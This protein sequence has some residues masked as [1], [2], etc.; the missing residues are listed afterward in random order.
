[1]RKAACGGRGFENL[2]PRVTGAQIQQRPCV[3]WLRRPLLGDYPKKIIPN[4]KTGLHPKLVI[5]SLLIR[6]DVRKLVRVK[7]VE[8]KG[9]I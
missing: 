8:K 6:E 4:I 3:L 7:T 1:M 2:L 9:A 5:T